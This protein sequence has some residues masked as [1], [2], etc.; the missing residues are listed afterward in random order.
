MSEESIDLT[1]QHPLSPN[2]DIHK[3]IIS[4]PVKFQSRYEGENLLIE[5]A[6]PCSLNAD[7]RALNH[8]N[9]Y[10]TGNVVSRYYYVCTFDFMPKRENTII[11]PD[12][13]QIGDFLCIALSIFYGKR[14]DNHGLIEG[15]G[16][17]WVPRY[18]PI[19]LNPCF[20]Y[21][22]ENHIFRV[23][24]THTYS[25]SDCSPIIDFM[26]KSPPETSD[27]EG[28][29]SL[30]NSFF[31]AGKFY[32]RSIQTIAQ[33]IERAYLDLITCGEILSNY[34]E[35]PDSEK[36]GDDLLS[37]LSR[38]EDKGVLEKDINQIKGRLYQVK[39]KFILMLGLLVNNIFF[40]R[41]ESKDADY[42]FAKEAPEGGYSFE[43]CMKAAYDLRSQYVHSGFSFGQWIEPLR[44]SA[45]VLNEIQPSWGTPNIEDSRAKNTLRKI[46]SYTGL[47]RVMRYALLRLLHTQGF[48][49]HQRLGEVEQ[50]IET[51]AQA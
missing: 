47:E 20:F 19:S 2:P 6:I 22:T 36:H 14:F 31:T 13:S 45:D 48:Y 34:Y 39:R 7:G 46:P 35:F 40:D 50:D 8:V 28:F 51:Q 42:R 17:F 30:W 1:Q 25:L 5:E 10:T 12:F 43:Q 21:P 29:Y 49:I 44:G 23:D 27:P 15:S 4:S 32:W 37:L 3:I 16:H 9:Q 26:L 38:L 24:G 18:E 41:T 11:I 33:D